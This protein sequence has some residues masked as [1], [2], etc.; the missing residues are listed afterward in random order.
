MKVQQLIN[1]LLKYHY[2]TDVVIVDAD[3]DWLL[4]I[5]RV[6]PCEGKLE[7]SA[8]YGDRVK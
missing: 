8:G 2:D 7:I 1:I 6:E 3:T 5:A 4:N